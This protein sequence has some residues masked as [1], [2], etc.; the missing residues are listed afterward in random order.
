MCVYPAFFV[1]ALMY[2]FLCVYDKKA[3]T[4]TIQDFCSH[5]RVLD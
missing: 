3:N 2:K 5:H 1:Y 4:F